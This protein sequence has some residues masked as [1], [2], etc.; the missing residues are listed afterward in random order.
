MQPSR[1]LLISLSVPSVHYHGHSIQ[2]EQQY[3]FVDVTGCCAMIR[4]I[5]SPPFSE[6][7]DAASRDKSI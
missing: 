7:L 2:D 1:G 3:L 5:Q 4:Q 6:P